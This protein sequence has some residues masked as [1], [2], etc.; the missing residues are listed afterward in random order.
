MN[1]F[2]FLLANFLDFP[3]LFFERLSAHGMT[4]N[5]REFLFSQL[6]DAIVCSN[7]VHLILI[8]K[9]NLWIFFPEPFHIRLWLKRLRLNHLPYEELKSSIL[10]LKRSLWQIQSSLHSSILNNL[11]SLFLQFCSL[12]F[13]SCNEI[14]LKIINMT[15][16]NLGNN[17]SLHSKNI[18]N[19][20]W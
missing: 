6:M 19:S 13:F 12:N 17:I 4:E 18:S 5:S 15:F 9:F 1:P 10:F 14:F 8:R 2:C 7:L 3:S 20:K 16:K 11:N